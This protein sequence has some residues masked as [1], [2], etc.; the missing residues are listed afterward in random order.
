MHLQD[1]TCSALDIQAKDRL[2]CSVMLFHSFGIGIGVC[3]AFSKGAS[4]VLPGVSGIRGCG[5]PAE[6]A[7]QS[8]QIVQESEARHPSRA[9]PPL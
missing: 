1:V 7:Q 9:A 8:K 4:V 6:R 3:A 2:V 5:S